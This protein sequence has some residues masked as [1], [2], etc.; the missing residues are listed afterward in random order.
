MSATPK[1]LS[2]CT[3]LVIG[4]AVEGA[5]VAKV[6]H[7]LGLKVTTAT[8]GDQALELF[9]TVRPDLVILD[10]K[11]PDQTGWQFVRAIR[12]NPQDVD[13]PAFVFVTAFHD[14]GNRLMAKLHGVLTNYLKKPADA[15]QLEAAVRRALRLA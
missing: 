11:L 3:A 13:E 7:S 5:R 15:Q 14:V 12:L 2:D 10:V 6:L 1:K 4:D 8:Q 9:Y